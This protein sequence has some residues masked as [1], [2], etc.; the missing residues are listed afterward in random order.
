MVISDR[1]HEAQEIKKY[2]TYSRSPIP[3]WISSWK[4]DGIQLRE[5]DQKN[6]SML[7]LSL[8]RKTPDG[9]PKCHILCSKHLQDRTRQ[10]FDEERSDPEIRRSLVGR[11]SDIHWK[12]EKFLSTYLVSDHYFPNCLIQTLRRFNSASV[13]E[14]PFGINIDKMQDTRSRSVVFINCSVNL[15]FDYLSVGPVRETRLR[16]ALPTIVAGLIVQT[17][18]RYWWCRIL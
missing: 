17:Q 14:D 10:I 7:Y 3:G 1:G 15:A 4:R 16:V 2:K 5:E 18:R 13:L 8:M 11:Q 9:C 6:G 12:E